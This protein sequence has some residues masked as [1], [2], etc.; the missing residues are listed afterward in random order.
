MTNAVHVFIQDNADTILHSASLDR[1]ATW[2]QPTLVNISSRFASQLPGCVHGI[3]VQGA[4]CTEPTCGGTAGHLLVPFVCHTAAVPRGDVKCPGCYSCIVSSSDHGET[5]VVGAAS[6][7]EGT[8]ESGLVQLRTSSGST[9][10]AT[11]Y[12]SERNMGASLG[13]REHAISLDSGLTFSEFG[14][15][16]GIPDVDTKNWTGVVAGVAR[17]DSPRQNRVVIT[18]PA[19]PGSRANLTAYVSLDEA[20]TWSQGALLYSGPAGYSDASQ[21]ND[22]ILGV[23]FENGV[24]EFAQQISFGWVTEADLLQ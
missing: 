9:K 18:T 4:Y 16:P 10:A 20:N 23:L 13:Y 12:S 3:T 5:W 19:G 7:Q 11:I 24:D 2:S 22:T 8:R 21:L 14:S 6:T 17:F 1:G 15:D